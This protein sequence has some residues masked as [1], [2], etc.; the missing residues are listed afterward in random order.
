MSIAVIDCGTNSTRLLVVDE[1]GVTLERLMTIT[2]LGQD[3]G[4]TG[5]LHPEATERVLDR[6]STR[7]N[8]SHT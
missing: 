8:S 5:R 3:L 1:D 2:R 4:R 6:K 7:L